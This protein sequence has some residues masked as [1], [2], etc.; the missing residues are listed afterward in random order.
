MLLIFIPAHNYSS[1]SKC[2]GDLAKYLQS[3]LVWVKDQRPLQINKSEV[4]SHG[5]EP[6]SR[7]GEE[8]VS[9]A[10]TRGSAWDLLKI[11]KRVWRCRLKK[12]QHMKSLICKHKLCKDKTDV[13][14]WSRNGAPARRSVPPVGHIHKQKKGWEGGLPLSL[15]SP[16]IPISR[17]SWDN[18]KW[19]SRSPST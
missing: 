8:Q 19:Q 15:S 14:K 5:L 2:Q 12:T 4:S 7:G 9:Q 17:S 3:G 10:E 18:I 13:A 11:F 6:N 16:L 1:E